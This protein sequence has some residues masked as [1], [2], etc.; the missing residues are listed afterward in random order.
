MV[1]L[2]KLY[3]TEVEQRREQMLWFLNKILLL[4][5]NPISEMLNVYNEVFL[6][7]VDIL[8][9]EASELFPLSWN[10]GQGDETSNQIY[11]S[12]CV[13]MLN[14]IKKN[15]YKIENK[16]ALFKTGNFTWSEYDDNFNR[17]RS[18]DYNDDYNIVINCDLV[19][20]FDAYLRFLNNNATKDKN[21][22]K[23][24]KTKHPKFPNDLK[25][26][27]ITI[28]FLNGNEVQ[29]TTRKTIYH[30]TYEE[31]GFLDKKTKNP[32]VQWDLLKLL[33]LRGGSLDWKNNGKLTIKEIGKIKKRKQLL[34]EK[35]EEYFNIVNDDPFLNYKKES[36]YK[37]K[38]HLIPE[39]GS[40]IEYNIYA[41]D[42]EYLDEDDQL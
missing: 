35:L 17:C 38:I 10:D 18:Y 1:K 4:S 9:K 12:F 34:S 27:E 37:I 28:R 33:S 7:P 14:N 8:G 19:P 39:E 40:K 26:E 30:S 15:L 21:E 20:I 32:N 11:A 13:G 36:A 3:G 5:K 24:D 6:F 41:D 29:I 25:W 2:N 31:M 16:I 22:S 23:I 42:S